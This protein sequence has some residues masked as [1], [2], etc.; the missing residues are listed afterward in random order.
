MRT[1]K[2]LVETAQSI[3]K[4]Q[5]YNI[6]LKLMKSCIHVRGEDP[7]TTRNLGMVLNLVGGPDEAE[8]YYR[9]SLGLN[10]EPLTPSG[11]MSDGYA[12]NA[13]TAPIL[14]SGD[15]PLPSDLVST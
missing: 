12:V 13:M 8:A 15:C 7:E 1:Y 6:A 2:E 4:K 5:D 11:S 14:T 9:K 3:I 10:N